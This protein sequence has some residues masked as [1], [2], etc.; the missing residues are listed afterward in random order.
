MALHPVLNEK[1]NTAVLPIPQLRA[2]RRDAVLPAVPGKVH[3]VIGMRRAG[4]TTFLRQLQ[5]EWRNSIPPERVVYLSFDDDR[6]AD[7]PMEQLGLLLEEYYRRYPELRGRETVRWL[8]D[9]VQLVNGWER[10]VRRVLDTERVE[11][12]VSGSSA[13]MLS[14][15]VHTSLRGRGMETVIRPFSFREFM[16]HRGTEPTRHVYEFTAV[17]RSLI[18]KEFR[19]YLAVGGFPEAQGLSGE[20]RVDLLQG[21]VDTVLFRDI[22]ERYGITQIAALRWLTRQCLR[23]PAGSLSVH[24]LYLDLKAQGLGVAKDSLH[25][26]MGHLQ[27]AFL[28]S[29]VTLAT[30]SER[31]RNSNPRKVYPVDTGLISAFDRSGRTNAGHAIETVVLHELQRRKAEIGYVRTTKGYEV[32]FHAGFPDGKEELIQVCADT[33]SGETLEREMRAMKDAA[34]DFP[35]AQQRFLVLTFDQLSAMT[36]KG[37]VSQPV[38]EWLLSESF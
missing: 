32:D 18:E 19:E 20:L 7:L 27:D 24:R 34:A 33:G 8:L 36:V 11:I 21:Y 35:R 38:Y 12:V 31:R 25:A 22:V 14:R 6:L 23:N 30:D 4:K 2:T 17:D 10:F 26:M 9:E 3:A 28:I 5:A 16:R 29:T 1:L 13:K 37:I 15:E